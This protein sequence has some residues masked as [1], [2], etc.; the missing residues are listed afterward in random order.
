[1]FSP[2]LAPK[3]IVLKKIFLNVLNNVY[4]C[5][6]F[7]IKLYIHL[8]FRIIKIKFKLELESGQSDGSETL[9]EVLNS[10]KGTENI[11]SF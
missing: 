10:K 11:M 9:I 6:I 4:T 5:T 1:M 2:A 3:D 7:F 8:N